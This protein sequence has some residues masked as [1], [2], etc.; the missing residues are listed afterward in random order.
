MVH[1]ANVTS[2]QDGNF[3]ELGQDISVRV[4]GE[5]SLVVFLYHRA[6]V[7][8]SCGIPEISRVHEVVHS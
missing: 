5:K 3:L 1:K 2:S 7:L 4:L 6:T 8:L